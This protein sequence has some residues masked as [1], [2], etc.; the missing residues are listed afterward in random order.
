MAQTPW[1]QSSVK[2]SRRQMQGVHAVWVMYEPIELLD[3]ESEL[4]SFQ[5]LATPGLS[6]TEV[7][8]EAGAAISRQ[9]RDFMI[10][11][12]DLMAAMKRL[13]KRG[14]YIVLGSVRHMLT[15]TSS[16]REWD[17]HDNYFESVRVHT[18]IQPEVIKSDG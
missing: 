17:Q 11:S 12:E 9:I 5:V 15:D 2:A 10:E 8:S 7:V 14:D 16:G 4:K 13:P 3:P 6:S 18:V 1:F